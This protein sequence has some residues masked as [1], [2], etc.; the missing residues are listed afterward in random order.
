MGGKTEGNRPLGRTRR[1]WKD[2]NEMDLREIGWSG[3]DCTDLN[4]DREEWRVLV[5]TLMN[6]RVP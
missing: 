3:M 5:N 6:P 2:N 1:R 4:Q